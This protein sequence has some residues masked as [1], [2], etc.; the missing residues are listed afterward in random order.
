MSQ[1]AR[2]EYRCEPQLLAKW[3]EKQPGTW[4][5][6]DGDPYLTSKMDFPCPVDELTEDLTSEKQLVVVISERNLPDVDSLE[7]V[8]QIDDLT[9]QV[10]PDRS[11]SDRLLLCRWEHSDDEWLLIEDQGAAKLF[12]EG[13]GEEP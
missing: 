9:D 12:G 4:W 10:A 13:D 2:R 11:A 7:T 3:L 8:D 1:L 5:F 6:V